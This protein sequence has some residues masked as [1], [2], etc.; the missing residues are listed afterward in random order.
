MY[1]C[2]YIETHTDYILYLGIYRY[3]F[4]YSFSQKS[5]DIY[6]KSFVIQQDNL[7]VHLE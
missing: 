6:R 2:M 5:G 4:V 3:L 7:K 1:V